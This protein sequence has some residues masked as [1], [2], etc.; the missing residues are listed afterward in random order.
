MRKIHEFVDNF[1]DE[2]KVKTSEN[3]SITIT[4]RVLEGDPVAMAFDASHI[5]DFKKILEALEELQ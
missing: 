4:F 2:V 5:P 3:G 1:S